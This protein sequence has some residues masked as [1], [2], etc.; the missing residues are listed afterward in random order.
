[1]RTRG[2]GIVVDHSQEALTNAVRQLIEDPM[3]RKTMGAAGRKT[4]QED[5]SMD[6]I[7]RSLLT[8]Y[9]VR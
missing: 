2:C 3:L 8:A 6:A 5:F 4:A 7:G 1:V 9:G